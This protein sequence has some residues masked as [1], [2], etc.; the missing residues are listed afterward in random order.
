MKNFPFSTLYKTGTLFALLVATPQFSYAQPDPNPRIIFTITDS[1]L[2]PANGTVFTITP[3][4]TSVHINFSGK[5][6][7]TV[8]GAA[9]LVKANLYFYQKNPDGTYPSRDDAGMPLPDEVIHIP[10]PPLGEVGE[11]ETSTTHLSS[12]LADDLGVGTYKIEYLMT[13]FDENTLQPGVFVPS[14]QSPGVRTSEFT[15][16]MNTIG[17]DDTGID[18]PGGGPRGGG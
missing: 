4:A 1:D 6:K 3:P 9:Y 15:V 8:N 17:I 14:L 10:K 13:A 18:N 7:A 5:G 12:N 2:V 11:A 16:V